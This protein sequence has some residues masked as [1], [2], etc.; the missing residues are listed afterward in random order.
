MVIPLRGQYEQQ[1]NAKALEDFNVIS[2]AELDE[3]FPAYFNKWIFQETQ[4]NLT[5]EHST[6]QIIDL[7]IDE[8]K[9]IFTEPIANEDPIINLEVAI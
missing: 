7:M 6:E 8:P 1:C 2:V 4:L 5:L 3:Y 9:K